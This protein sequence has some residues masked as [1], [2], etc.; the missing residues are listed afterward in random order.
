M[1]VNIFDI[2]S[3]EKISKTALSLWVEIG[4]CVCILAVYVCVFLIYF[5]EFLSKNSYAFWSELLLVP[6][7]FCGAVFFFRI[8]LWNNKNIEAINWN[9]TRQ[10]YYQ[11]LLQKGRAYLDVIELQVRLPD[12]NG[13]V[14]NSIEGKLLPVRYAPKLTHMSR[15]LTFNSPI[16]ELISIYQMQER[17]AI[18]FSKIIGGIINDIHMHL[19]L[20]PKYVRVKVVCVLNDNLKPLIKKIWQERLD[21]IYL[22]AN[23]EFSKNLSESIDNWLDRSSDEY[24][25]LIAANFHGAELLD[26]EIDNKSESVVFLFGRLRNDGE[27]GDH[28]SL[29]A[30]FRPECDW[31]G[32]D[33]SLLWGRVNEGRGLSGVIYSGLNE[34][35]LKKMVLKTTDVM[36]ESALSSYMYVDSD[37]YLCKCPPLTEFLQLS[38]VNEHLPPGQYLL[39]SK[40]NDI[41]NSHLFNSAASV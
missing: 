39:I 15:Y 10:D 24:I 3:E 32:I 38:Y 22:G 20:L 33:K 6:L 37:N 40:N 26:D 21:S 1:P 8:I 27:T 18:L 28:S 13:N 14:T 34:E 4:I 29:G 9:R 7:L 11:E 2:P 35:E 25:V 23:I 17:N 41:L 30:F 5:P 19:S 12:L 16:P 31:A 36:S